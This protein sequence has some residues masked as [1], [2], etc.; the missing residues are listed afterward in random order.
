MKKFQL[1]VSFLF[2]L[3]NCFAQP[4][5]WVWIHGPNSV[6]N[7]GVFGV[8]GVSGPSNNPPSFYEACEWTDQNGNFWMFGGVSF[9]G[10]YGDVWKYNPSSNE[11]TWMKGTG[12]ANYITIYGTMGVP[13]TTNDP[14]SRA[15][16]IATW[17][18]LQGNFWMFGGSKNGN[19]YADLWRFQPSTNIWTWMKGPQGPGGAGVYG[20]QGIPDTANYPTCRYETSATWTDNSGDLWFF[21]G[22]GPAGCNND[23][24]KYNISSNEWTWM[25]GSQTIAAP[26]V[27]GQQGVEDP[28]N[29]PGARNIYSHWKD[30]NGNFWIF[31]GTNDWT[32][33]YND[34][35]KYNPITNN[36]TWMKGGASQ[37]FYLNQCTGNSLTTPGVRFESRACVTDVDGN[38]WLLGGAENLNPDYD[39]D[40]WM[41]CVSLNKWIWV[42]GDNF[43]NSLGYWGTIGISSPLNRPDGRCGSIM[44]YDQA[45]HLYVF[46]G[47]NG[48]ISPFY[49]N[50]LWKF[51]IDPSCTGCTSQP[52]AQFSAPNL[53]CPGTCTNFLNSSINSTSY[54]WN[55]PG[56]IPLSSNDINPT[57]ICYNTPGYYDVTLIA[58]N[59]TGNDTLTLNNF[60]TVFPVPPAQGIIQNDDT[61]I[62]NQ[63]SITYQWFFNGTL[64]SGATNYFYIAPQSGNYSVVA[65]DEN[66]CEVEAVINNV[67]ASSSQLAMDSWQLAINSNPVAD[68]LE[69]QNLRTTEK[70]SITVYNTLGG[71]TPLPIANCQLPTCSL[72][73]STLPYGIYFLEIISE[74][75]IYRTKF[76]KQ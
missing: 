41:Y 39:N 57:N 74:S 63:G 27:Y 28:A 72:D 60:I 19:L 31:G 18:D 37:A 43:S 54:T 64:I 66:N 68:I 20:T 56:G 5:E 23:L 62:A 33:Y 22:H 51:T 13:S 67:I 59:A 9:V 14:G 2:M 29:T 7:A 3:G 32:T 71:A 73:V 46:G 75:K 1:I 47:M 42:A 48:T 52:S 8:Q 15:W 34:L 50:D 12:G 6:N 17:V 38:F 70:I 40:V 16:G 49:R 45:G 4:G 25:K 44:W 24:W 55:F 30:L 65:S 58:S 36:W 21:G 26:G 10:E 61:L 53:I 11:W 76:L 35:W 69:I